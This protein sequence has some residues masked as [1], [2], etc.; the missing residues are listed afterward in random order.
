MHTRTLHFMCAFLQ[1][2]SF[3]LHDFT[4]HPHTHI[5][6]EK[7]F[8]IFALAY[9]LNKAS[10][11]IAIHATLS[12]HIENHFT[13]FWATITKVFSYLNC[14]SRLN[15]VSPNFWTDLFMYHHFSL[16][17]FYLPNWKYTK[18]STN[19]PLFDTIGLRS[20]FHLDKIIFLKRTLTKNYYRKVQKCEN[21]DNFIIS[22][23]QKLINLFRKFPK[24]TLSS[25]SISTH[26]LV[27]K[28]RYACNLSAAHTFPVQH[29]TAQLV[30]LNDNG[31]THFRD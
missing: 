18:A 5:Q 24:F 2:K 23:V 28:W 1:W 9:S 27:L 21:V 11:A 20:S 31:N 12:T 30:W 19:R 15:C 16:A 8:V 29:H 13:A 26:L 10:I 6:R 22:H 25:S 7:L 4:I 3:F 14:I 17:I